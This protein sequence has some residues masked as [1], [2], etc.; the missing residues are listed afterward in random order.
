MSASTVQIEAWGFMIM[1]D[2]FLLQLVLLTGTAFAAQ[3]FDVVVCG[4]TS[5]GA[6]A[7]GDAKGS[8]E[9]EEGRLRWLRSFVT[10]T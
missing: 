3:E 6:R 1:R 8:E 5:G 4:G 2:Q 9:A 7:V 10:S